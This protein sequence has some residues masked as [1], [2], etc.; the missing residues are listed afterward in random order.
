VAKSISDLTGRRN[1]ASE[2][3]LAANQA[4]SGAAKAKKNEES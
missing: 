3:P 1:H 4:A 2:N